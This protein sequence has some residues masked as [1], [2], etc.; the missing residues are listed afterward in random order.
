MAQ[1]LSER[2]RKIQANLNQRPGGGF[3]GGPKNFFG[4]AA[5]L[6]LLVGGVVVANNALYN[7]T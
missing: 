4:G 1:D 5:G 2:F 3:P 7:G 6:A